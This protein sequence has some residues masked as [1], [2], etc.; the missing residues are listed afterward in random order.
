MF[1]NFAELDPGEKVSFILAVFLA[2]G[3]M[4][5][6]VVLWFLTGHHF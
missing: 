5:G 6:G 1:K 2:L 4:V 3:A